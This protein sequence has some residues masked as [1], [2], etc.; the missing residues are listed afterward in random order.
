MEF[1][2]T[3]FA[4]CVATTEEETTTALGGIGIS[5]C[6]DCMWF[7]LGCA[8]FLVGN[9]A[10]DVLSCVVGYGEF[11]FGDAVVV[12]CYCGDDVYCE[13]GVGWIMEWYGFILDAVEESLVYCVGGVD[14]C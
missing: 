2:K 7:Y 1:S 12:S 9:C 4:T 13:F 6:G 5:G 14:C 10:G 8:D 3:K 11:G